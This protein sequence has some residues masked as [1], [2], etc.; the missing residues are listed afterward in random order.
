[1]EK[2]MNDNNRSNRKRDTSPTAVASVP[3]TGLDVLAY[4]GIDSKTNRGVY[5]F[6]LARRNRS[7]DGYYATYRVENLIDVIIACQ[8]AAKKFALVDELPAELRAELRELS[9]RLG[10]TLAEMAAGEPGGAGAPPPQRRP[11]G[12]AAFGSA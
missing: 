1:V 9:E 8:F 2:N 5:H 6:K 3:E 12:L 11:N 7:G 4:R 10:T